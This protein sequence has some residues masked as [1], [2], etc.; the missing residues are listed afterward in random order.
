M[1]LFTKGLISMQ[2]Q[3]ISGFHSI[4]YLKWK[5]MHLYQH[6]ADNAAAAQGEWMLRPEETERDKLVKESN[7]E[8]VSPEGHEPISVT[9]ALII[10]SIH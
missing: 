3:A 2:W 10:F 1:A 4:S 8:Q 6:I 5:F 7:A 9:M